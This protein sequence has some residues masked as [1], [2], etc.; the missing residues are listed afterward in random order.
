MR[1]LIIMS[2]GYITPAITLLYHYYDRAMP[3]DKE[4]TSYPTRAI[5]VSDEV[6]EKL[7]TKKLKS[8]LT[9][10]NFFEEIIRKLKK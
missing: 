10:T 1:P 8:N 4:F 9:W 6:W 3:K 7:K 2:E 5:T